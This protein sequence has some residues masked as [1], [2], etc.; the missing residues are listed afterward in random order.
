M[1]SGSDTRR[2]VELAFDNVSAQSEQQA[3]QSRD[4]A[5]ELAPETTLFEVWLELVDYIKAWNG[6][7]E[8][9]DPM[10]RGRA[11]QFFLNRQAELNDKTE[12]T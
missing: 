5:A 1:M 9:K 12:Q 7:P 10:G 3:A 4:E 2:L 8:H 11:L 6:N